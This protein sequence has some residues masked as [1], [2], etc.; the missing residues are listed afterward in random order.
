MSRNQE[1]VVF[2]L[3]MMAGVLAVYFIGGVLER[4]IV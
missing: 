3:I 2:A 4:I 1:N